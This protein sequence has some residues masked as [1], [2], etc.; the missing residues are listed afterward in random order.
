M[1]DTRLAVRDWK[2]PHAETQRRREE[3]L[4]TKAKKADKGK[5]KRR[6]SPVGE[7]E[8]SANYA[9]GR[10]CGFL[11]RGNSCN[12]LIKKVPGTREIGIMMFVIAEH[13]PQLH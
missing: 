3:D 13:I 4:T 11:V 1:P 2:R 7:E 8:G 6:L 12:S 5:E 10:E 9:N